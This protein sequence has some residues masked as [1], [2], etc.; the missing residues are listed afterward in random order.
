MELSGIR[1]EDVG[2]KEGRRKGMEG[3]S[4]IYNQYKCQAGTDAFRGNLT[5]GLLPRDLGVG[6][7]VLVPLP[8]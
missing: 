8:E 6:A 2:G 3:D 7:R 4:D 1:P 5:C